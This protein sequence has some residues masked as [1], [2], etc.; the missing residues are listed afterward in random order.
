M[1]PITKAQALAKANAEIETALEAGSMPTAEALFAA[2][3][4]SGGVTL[5]VA[6]LNIEPTPPATIQ[7]GVEGTQIETL[8]TAIRTALT[9]STE[10]SM[11]N[12]AQSFPGNTYQSIAIT[13][14]SGSFTLTV[15]GD[16]RTVS[17]TDASPGFV[18]DAAGLGRIATELSIS[19]LSAGAV[20]NW[21][22]T[23]PGLG[24]NPLPAN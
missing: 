22:A 23:T 7:E 13:A 24:S 19:G 20:V 12:G 14:E 16:T 6:A 18:I 1:A 5:D 3:L 11:G 4:L 8:L 10:V 9:G 17:S 2:Y 21:M 15:G